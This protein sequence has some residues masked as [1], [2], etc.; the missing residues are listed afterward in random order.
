MSNE[1]VIEFP[2]K[3]SSEVAAP[4]GIVISN[5]EATAVSEIPDNVKAMIKAD[6]IGRAHV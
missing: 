6:E 4:V 5:G 1:N 3:E 2:V